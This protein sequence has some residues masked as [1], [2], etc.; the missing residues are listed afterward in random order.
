MS[1]TPLFG[2]LSSHRIAS[3]VRQATHRVCYAAPG[4]QDEVAEALVEVAASSPAIVVSL[5]LDFDERTLRMGYGSLAAVEKLRRA[6]IHPLLSA[7]FRSAVLIVDHSGWVFTPIALYLEAEPHGDEAPNA[8]RLNEAQVKELLIRLCPATQKEAVSRATT[9]E[10]KARISA[11]SEE[12]RGQPLDERHLAIVKESIEL[13]PPV[14]FDV[15][16]QV[17]VFEPYLQYVELTLSGAA[18]QRHR[19]RIPQPIQQLGSSKDLEG[20]LRI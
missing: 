7:G 1:D 19:V 18:I 11:V 2:A 8:I 10:E 13:A 3:L 12:V 20:R 14:K 9:P 6:N 16:R 5:C 17:R 4:I 15:V